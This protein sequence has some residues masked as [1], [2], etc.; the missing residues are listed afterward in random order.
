M[1]QG[2]VPAPFQGPG[3]PLYQGQYQPNFQQGSQGVA[4]GYPVRTQ[5][6]QDGPTMPASYDREEA[7]PKV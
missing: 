1:Q 5:P 6:A 2:P 3:G 4:Y 7:T